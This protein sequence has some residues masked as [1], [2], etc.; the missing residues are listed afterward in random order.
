MMD[1]MCQSN[2]STKMEVVEN[3]SWL[4]SPGKQPRNFDDRSRATTVGTKL[5]HP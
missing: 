1:A 3:S 2:G 4:L 5:H